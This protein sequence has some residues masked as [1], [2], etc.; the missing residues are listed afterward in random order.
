MWSLRREGRAKREEWLRD[1]RMDTTTGLI[2]ALH[3]A[4]W[5]ALQHHQASKRAAFEPTW[6]SLVNSVNEVDRAGA[7]VKLTCP[8]E[9]AAAA[10]SAATAMRDLGRAVLV[11]PPQIPVKVMLF[12]HDLG[13]A[14]RDELEAFVVSANRL[15]PKE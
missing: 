7:L 8:E 5:S 2:S 14:A 6:W 9:L 12:R 11:D 15:L 4:W 10:D 3:M 1:R 13:V